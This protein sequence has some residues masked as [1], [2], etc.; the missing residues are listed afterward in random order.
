MSRM[1]SLA[2][3][4]MDRLSSSVRS[5]SE[6][7]TVCGPERPMTGFL[8]TL[9]EAQKKQALAYRGPD[10]HGDMDLAN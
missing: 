4:V 10:S 3:V 7:E 6:P 9:S 8:A 5:R 1:Q 2:Q